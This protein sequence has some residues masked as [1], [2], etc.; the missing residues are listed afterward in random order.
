VAHL[1]FHPL[2][3]TEVAELTDE[4]VAITLDVPQELAV[5]FRY[6]PGQ[7]VVVRAMVDGVDVRRSYSICANALS[8]K[9]RIGVKRLGDGA[10]STFATTRLRAGDVLE[11]MPPIGDFTIDPDPEC[12]R[13]RCAI[14]A[15][16]GITPVLSLV[17]TSLEAEPGARW[18]V[19]FGNREARSIMFLDELEGLKDRH[20]SRLHLLHLLSREE[21]VPILS[22]RIDASRLTELFHSLVDFRSIDEWFLCGPHELVTT[23]RSFLERHGADPSSIHEEQFFAGPP[24]A[25][26]VLESETTGSVLLTFTLDGRES[27][28]R[29]EPATSILDAA[30][31]VRPELPYSC[32]GG[33]CASCKARV[34]EGEV[35]MTRNYA[36][37]PEDLDRGFTLTCQAHPVGDRVVVDFDQR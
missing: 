6:L 19:I 18:T 1:Q 25:V 21:T 15:G 10:F 33:M 30:L 11:V 14:V 4:S 8:G 29:L 22:G 27:T 7:H 31:A 16:S 5:T 12:R 37:V 32:K 24:P 35:A 3:V 28:V 26:P 20:G 34:I 13:H 36:L 17:A 23:A 9:L 2:T